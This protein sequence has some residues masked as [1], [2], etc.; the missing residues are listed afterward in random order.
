MKNSRLRSVLV[1]VPSFL[2]L[3][4][5]RAQTPAAPP[6]APPPPPPEMHQVEFWLGD[7]DVFANGTDQQIGESRV[8]AVADGWALLESWT[9]R[10]P[11]V[12]GKSLNSFD[13]ASG[14]W[15]QFWIGGGGGG[16]ILFKG[17][18][19]DGKMV[20]E[21]TFVAAKGAPALT[22]GIWTPNADGT[23]R[24]QFENS[25]DGGKTWQPNFDGL[26]KRKPTR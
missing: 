25:T 24:Q 9:A 8:E 23:V 13:R 1:L 15:Q 19:V 11:K 3:A 16:I 10:G 21:A 17:G 12:T 6:S 14:Q 18:L 4:T 5:M 2:L 22:R 20:L 7:W 26:Y